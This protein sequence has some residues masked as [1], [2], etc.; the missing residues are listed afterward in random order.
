MDFLIP[1]SMFAMIVA[2]VYLHYRRKERM[3]II[4]RGLDLRLL[5]PK[6]GSPHLF[7]SLKYGM[8]LLLLGTGL[9]IANLLIS[10]EIMEEE[11]AYFSLGSLSVGLALLLYYFIAGRLMRRQDNDKQEQE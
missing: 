7:S 3:A 2:I 10:N 4:E 1:I 9:L 8:L 6:H 11:P 5:E